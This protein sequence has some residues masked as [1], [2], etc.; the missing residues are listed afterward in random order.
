MTNQQACAILNKLIRGIDPK[1]GEILPGDHILYDPDVIRALGMGI[2]ALYADRMTPEEPVRPQSAA[3]NSSS[4]LVPAPEE[5][6]LEPPGKPNAGRVWT[7]TDQQK[8]IRLY[9]SGT[10]MKEIC[11]L[12]QR[13]ERGVKRQLMY[14]GQ[15]DS[16][17]SKSPRPGLERM[18][19]PWTL[20]E[21][22]KLK[23]LYHHRL[24]IEDIAREL[25]RSEYG[26][27]CHMEKLDL[28]GDVPGYPLYD[29]LP[30]WTSADNK[31]LTELF[32]QGKSTAEI[33]DYFGRSEKSISARMFYMG[34]TR[35]SPPTLLRRRS[36]PDE[37]E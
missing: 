1:S 12:L 14:L 16:P 15:I 35:Q 22:L 11:R 27:Y 28:Y 32:R 26:V 36:E 4:P 7:K 18:G 37:N 23:Q 13:R 3:R 17:E 20:D 8:L 21:E 30:M 19:K 24:P 31:K 9:N 6:L 25:H 10:P 33:A 29:P 2:A 5:D 34:L